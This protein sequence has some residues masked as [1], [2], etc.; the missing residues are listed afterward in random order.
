MMPWTLVPAALLEVALIASLVRK[1][2][3]AAASIELRDALNVAPPLW[4]AIGVL[5]GCAAVGLVAGLIEPAAG[6]AAAFGSA[7]LMAG[8]VIAHLRVGLGGR[9][10]VAP[11][12]LLAS[13]TSAGLGFAASV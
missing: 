4:S 7:L 12:V 10:L 5:E 13:A 6:A 9:R 3:R 8:A 2:H 1:A 11:L